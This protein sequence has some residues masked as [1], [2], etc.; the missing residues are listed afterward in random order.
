MFYL[1]TSLVLISVCF[2]LISLSK[3]LLYLKLING[4]FF[5]HVALCKVAFHVLLCTEIIYVLEK[6]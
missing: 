2:L 1:I 6:H 4:D 3:S 5:Q